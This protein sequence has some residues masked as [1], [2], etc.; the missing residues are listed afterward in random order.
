M[1]TILTI[2]QYDLWAEDIAGS[3]LTVGNLMNPNNNHPIFHPVAFNFQLGPDCKLYAYADNTNAHHV[4]RYP[5][6]L[7]LACQ[8]EQE[9]M[10]LPFPVFRDQPMFPNFRLGPAGKESSPCAAPIVSQR[11][12]VRQ[13]RQAV[14]DIYPNPARDH[15]RLSL[16]FS[17]QY[18]AGTWRLFDALGRPVK[19]AQLHNGQLQE[20]TLGDLP[21]GL[22]FWHFSSGAELVDQGKLVVE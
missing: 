19:T 17:S 3:R 6:E 21:A 9:A 10:Q 4:I 5:D 16:R 13:S 11:E 22:Y 12:V 20:L 15:L 1:S 2:Y 14:V 18:P 7:G 8:W